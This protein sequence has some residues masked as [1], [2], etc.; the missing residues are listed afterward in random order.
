MSFF[1]RKKQQAPAP[2]QPANVTV[3]N[4]PSQALAQ[5]SNTANNIPPQQQQQQQQPGSLR[6]NNPLDP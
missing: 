2:A 3:A 1:S 5:L 6:D 4:T